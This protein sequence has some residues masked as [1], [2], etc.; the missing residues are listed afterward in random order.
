MCCK[1]ILVDIAILKKVQ[2]EEMSAAESLKDFRRI[3]SVGKSIAQDLFDLGFCSVNEL[4]GQDPDLL[5]E[6]LCSLRKCHIDRCMLYFLRCAV[7]FA[8]TEDPDGELL[9]WWNWKD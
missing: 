9:K 3:P 6:K 5:Y 4:K 8:Q 2:R 1:G 7:Y